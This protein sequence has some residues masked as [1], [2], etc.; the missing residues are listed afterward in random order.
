MSFDSFYTP[1]DSDSEREPNSNPARAQPRRPEPPS[2]P[3]DVE[4]DHADAAQAEPRPKAPAAADPSAEPDFSD[5]AQPSARRRAAMA[6]RRDTEP[7]SSDP[8]AA[9][10]HRRPGPAAADAETGDTTPW[11]TAQ[12]PSV[13]AY[14]D[15]PVVKMKRTFAWNRQAILLAVLGV[16]VV[17]LGATFFMKP[18]GESVRAIRA[19]PERF[20]GRQIMIRGTVGEVF[21]MGMSCAYNLHQGWRGRDTLVV[22]SRIRFPSSGNSVKVFGSLS[23]GYLD[24]QARPALFETAAPE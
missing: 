14:F 1:F 9:Q 8:A 7:D 13:S 16:C 11:P 4:P 18:P 24:G 20:D 2:K 17:A 6:A 10:P 3:P 23:T 15:E 19:H 21:P 12:A 5:L 22:F